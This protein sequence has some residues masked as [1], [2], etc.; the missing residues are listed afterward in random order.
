MKVKKELILLSVVIV[1][2][3]LYLIFRNQDNTHYKLPKLAHI[4]GKQI[5]KIEILT[6]ETSIVLN[7]KDN[8]WHIGPDEYPANSDKIE[9]MLDVIEGLSLTALVSESENYNRYDLNDEKKITIKAWEEGAVKRTFD[10]G[11]AA[12]SFRHTFVK[13]GNDDRVY[14]A[15]G[16][17]INDFGETVEELRDKTVLAFNQDEIRQVRITKE[18]T[19]TQF[20]RTDIP[21]DVKTTEE[22]DTA[23]PPPSQV[24]TIWKTADDKKGDNAN[25]ERLLN[26]LSNL[27]CHE[28]INDSKKED[29]SNPICTIELKGT[30]EYRLSIFPKMDKE[31]SGYPAISSENNYPFSLRESQVDNLM[32]E[33]DELVKGM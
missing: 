14:H 16:N 15:R 32:K 10:I 11:K 7:K 19:E 13:L 27:N 9:K 4:S 5:S 26:S 33:P 20:T 24:Q 28:Y 22:P 2:L 1:G 8:S 23:T 31:A 6:Q 18:K 30:K 25:I 29:F 21:I 17:F 3:S 12:S